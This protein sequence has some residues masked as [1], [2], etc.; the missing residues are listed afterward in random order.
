LQTSI[1][2][3]DEVRSY[4]SDRWKTHAEWHREDEKEEERR[5]RAVEER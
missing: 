1:E 2:E 3:V 4:V 5:V